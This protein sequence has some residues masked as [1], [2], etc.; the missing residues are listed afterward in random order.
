MWTCF[1]IINPNDAT[2]TKIKH[3]L[4][5]KH[6]SEINQLATL[7]NFPGLI[8]TVTIKFESRQALINDKAG[9]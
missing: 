8:L 3:S 1:C 2:I 7:T 4:R 9:K 5:S 6:I